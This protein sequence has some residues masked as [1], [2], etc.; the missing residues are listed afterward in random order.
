[1]KYAAATCPTGWTTGPDKCY[2]FTGQIMNWSQAKAY[3]EDLSSLTVGGQARYPSLLTIDSST[4]MSSFLTLS[5]QNKNYWLN[6]EDSQVEG[7]FVCQ[8]T[9]DGAVTDYSCKC[10]YCAVN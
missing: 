8:T 2:L 7:T 10:S 5:P 6:C 1:M 3:C 4:E 9:R